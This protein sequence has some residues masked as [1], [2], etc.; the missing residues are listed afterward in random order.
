[1]P[2][3]SNQSRIRGSIFGVAVVDAL[4]GPV[5]FR[6][7]GSFPKVAGYQHNHHFNVPPGTWTDDTSMTLCL[8]QGL[9]DSKGIFVPQAAIRNYI[10]WWE[11]GYLSATGY[12]FDIG[13][14]TATAL[15]IWKRYFEQQRSMR[16]DDPRGHEG[17]L[18][19]INKA[20]NYEKCCG[21]GSLMRV[22]PVGLVYSH[23]IPLAIS[24]AAQSSAVTHPY[25]ACT[26][27]CMLYTKLIACAMNGGTKSDIANVVS[28]TTYVDEKVKGIFDRYA[29]VDD[30]VTTE[31]NSINS[32]GYVITT[33]EAALWSFFSTNSFQ[34]GAFKVVN[35]GDDADTV[36]AVYGGLA[37]A[38][39]G[40][41]SIPVEWI[42]GLQRKDIVA[43]IAM[44]LIS[45][46]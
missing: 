15:K 39:Y 24:I 43:E 35:L 46:S 13:N 17:A 44:G 10:K 21:N 8:A 33:L 2:T 36:G 14:A 9:I 3:L 41:D 22:S 26:E 25:P 37:G 16:E 27:C 45:L 23:D 32:S 31:E 38:F 34:D 28:R 1:M 12:C 7:R 20:L 42:D 30:W 6:A 19:E 40:F 29:G 5:E 18:S 4:G 11:N